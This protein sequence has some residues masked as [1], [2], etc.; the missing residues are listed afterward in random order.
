MTFRVRCRR[1][2]VEWS[3]TGQSRPANFSRLATKPV[4]WRSGRPNST[5]IV[6]Q[7]WIAASL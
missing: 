5:L 4:V 6:R 1:H 7:A 3:G 2:S